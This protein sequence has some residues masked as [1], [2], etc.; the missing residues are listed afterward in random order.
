MTTETAPIRRP[1]LRSIRERF[2]GGS[3]AAMF[4]LLF[5]PAVLLALVLYLSLSTEF[6]LT[7]VNIRNIFLQ[8]AVLAVVAFGAT[9]VILSGELDL[10]VGAGVALV[11]VV[12]ALVMR[13]TGSIALGL[14]VGLGAGTAFGIINGALVSVLQIPS[15]IATLGTLVTAQ[16]AALALTGGA[17]VSDLPQGIGD[18][19]NG[20][21]LGIRTIL[22]VVIVTF[23]VLY[24]VQSQTSFGIKVLAVG[25]NR[26]AA[27]LAGISVNW[28]R[29]WCFVITGVAVGIGGLIVTARVQSGQPT[30][31]SLLGLMSIAAIVVGGTNLLGGRG[32]VART[33]FGVLLITVLQN[34]LD[35]KGVDDDLQ[36]VIIGGVFIA[37]ASTD[38]IRQHLVARSTRRAARMSADLGRSP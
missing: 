16:G 14:I 12:S 36:Q 8:G 31:G 29:F 37:A 30:T 24:I 27:R 38:F 32:S 25:G 17:V 23:V 18:L 9:Y 34:G 13:D 5:V 33:L 1:G 35:L 26:E 11:S 28:T 2:G 4:D 6:F 7:G 3:S 22:W 19:A 21:F 10:S 20:S 15:F